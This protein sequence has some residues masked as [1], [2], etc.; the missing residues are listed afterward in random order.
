MGVN[1][2]PMHKVADYLQLR[3]CRVGCDCASQGL[4]SA[5]PGLT[6]KG[7][8]ADACGVAENLD[9]LTVHWLHGAPRKADEP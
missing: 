2:Y 9:I 8:P 3:V 4:A 6:A 7:T 1:H 5:R